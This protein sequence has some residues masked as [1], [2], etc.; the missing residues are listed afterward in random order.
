MAG[1]QGGG[2]H[3]DGGSRWGMG[4][5]G[6]VSTPS[7]DVVPERWAPLPLQLTSEA[8]AGL[9]VLDLGLQDTLTLGDLGAVNPDTH[10]H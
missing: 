2:L 9:P 7:I 10:A 1:G 8:I 5:D 6:I 4:S 3:L